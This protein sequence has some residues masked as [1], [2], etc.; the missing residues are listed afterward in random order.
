[1]KNLEFPVFKTKS[2]KGSPKF[3]LSDPKQRAKY[4][5]FKAGSEIAHLQDYLK[6]N[7]FLAIMLGKKAA[8]KGTYSKLF[9]EALGSDKT[10]LVSVGDIVREVHQVLEGGKG[11]LELMGFLEKNYRG[12]ISIEEGVKAI[13]GRS[14]DRISVPDEFM[15]A[16]I[17]REI[18][19]HTGKALFIDGFPRTAD[20][21]SYSLFFRDLA[22]YRSDPDIFVMIDIPE[23]VI[24]ERMKYRVICPK[25]QVPR[26]PRLLLSKF[27]EYDPE[28]KEFYLLC[29]DPKC[30]RSRMHRKEGDDKGI[31]SI[32]AR[33]NNDE[34]LIKQAFNLYGVPK[35]LLRNAVPV[36]RAEEMIDDYEITPAYRHRWDTKKKKVVT[37]E[38]PWVFKDDQGVDSY[39]LLAAPVV[40]SLIKQMADIL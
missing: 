22:G 13:L 8:G 25:C 12:Y 36:T 10:V 14:Q 23:K 7:T 34:L 16:L 2:P 31:E 19:N 40:V 32:R 38:V 5:Q 33:L 4:F 11:K 9:A 37:R 15:L 17:K 24:D 29:D 39:S 20:Q 27:V 1:M 28:K 6:N 3:D 18:E 30:G 21:V 35:I 26:N